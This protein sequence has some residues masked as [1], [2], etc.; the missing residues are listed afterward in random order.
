MTFRFH[1]LSVFSKD[2]G[3]GKVEV[4]FDH[5]CPRSSFLCS[6]EMLLLSFWFVV[7]LLLIFINAGYN[8]ACTLFV[9]H[10]QVVE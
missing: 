9:M 10:K 7:E 8:F 5:C 2:D 1:P 3:G 6:E 4:Q